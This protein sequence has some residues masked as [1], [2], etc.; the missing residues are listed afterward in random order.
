M[1]Y[2]EK[3][4]RFLSDEPLQYTENNVLI[5]Q[6]YHV[7]VIIMVKPVLKYGCYHLGNVIIHK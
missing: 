1:F 6:Q 2:N 7:M 5:S 3:S 4:L